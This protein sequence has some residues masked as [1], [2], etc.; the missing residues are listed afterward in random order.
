MLKLPKLWCL[1][2]FGVKLFQVEHA[3]HFL[4]GD[5]FW[6][7]SIWIMQILIQS[8][9]EVYAVKII[10]LDPDWHILDSIHT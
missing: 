6:S 5:T 2:T 7:D 1:F 9:S 4:G 3:P 10:W 8:E